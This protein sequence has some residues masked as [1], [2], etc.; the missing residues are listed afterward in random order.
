MSVSTKKSS[1]L[2]NFPAL[3][4]EK[5]S[6]LYPLTSICNL[7]STTAASQEISND[8]NKRNYIVTQEEHFFFIFKCSKARSLQLP[9]TFNNHNQY[10]LIAYPV[11]GIGLGAFCASSDLPLCDLGRQVLLSMTYQK[12]NILHLV[13]MF[14]MLM[15]MLMIITSIISFA[16][17]QKILKI[18]QRKEAILQLKPTLLP[19]WQMRHQFLISLWSKCG[20]QHLSGRR[21]HKMCK[22]Q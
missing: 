16:E 3:M 5:S 10:F 13:D 14:E 11:P 21:L 9:N 18:E 8:W 12:A 20:F 4:R 17:L 2:A 7:S 19:S 1:F 15:M 22:Q 6:Q